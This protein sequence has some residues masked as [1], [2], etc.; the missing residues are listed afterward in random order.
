MGTWCHKG[1]LCA[2]V[3]G[4]Y[5]ALVEQLNEE[6]LQTLEQFQFTHSLLEHTPTPASNGTCNPLEEDFYSI[7]LFSP[8]FSLTKWASFFIELQ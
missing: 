4:F 5:F 8:P 7:F 6:Y 3:G 2:G 1:T